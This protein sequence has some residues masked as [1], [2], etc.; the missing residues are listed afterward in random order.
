MGK[1]PVGIV[2]VGNCASSLLQGIEFYRAGDREP[3]GLMHPILGGYRPGDI[4]VVCAG[5]E[6]LMATVA[7]SDFDAVIVSAPTGTKGIELLRRGHGAGHHRRQRDDRHVT[8]RPEGGRDPELVDD[9]AVR[10]VVVG[11]GRDRA[12]LVLRPPAAVGLGAISIISATISKA[13]TKGGMVVPGGETVNCVADVRVSESSPTTP[14]SA[15]IPPLPKCSCN[16]WRVCSSSSVINELRPCLV[17]LIPRPS[18]R[19]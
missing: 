14:K 5:S 15:I 19:L 7:E 4:E 17:G 2:G 6:V 18:M 3:I 10:P 13:W 1:I 11:V 16:A 12:G 8:A 9:L